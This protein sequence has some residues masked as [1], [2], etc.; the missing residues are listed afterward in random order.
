[1]K[2]VREA[3]ALYGRIGRTYV[4]W[5]RALLPLA[6]LVFIP[7][8]LV[9]AVPIHA[10]LDSVDT[11]GG[12]KALTLVGAVAVL[13]ATGLIG[14]VF[15]TGAVSIALTHPTMGGR[16]PAVREVARR[17]SYWRLI[18]VDLIYG[19]VVS[20]G[21]I[22]FFVPGALIYV[23]LGLA[24]PAVEIERFGVRAGFARSARLV[25]GHFWLV[26]WVLVPIELVGDA[27]T[28][29]VTDVAAH[30]LG[31]SLV[32]EWLADTASN[33]VVTPVYAVAAVLLTL[34]LIAAREGG[35]PRLH[36]TPARA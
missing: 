24:A 32:A 6:A 27:V 18:A 35:G 15:Y 22:A 19:L 25:A 1:M 14:E 4:S 17:I 33:I 29:V 16:P 10:H 8:G 7:L 13:S 30:L 21:L 2:S 36:K 9:H 31:G 26:F 3:F 28:N 23:F 12:L 11:A 34:D 20:A 5:A